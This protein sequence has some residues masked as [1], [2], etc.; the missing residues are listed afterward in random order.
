MIP[1]SFLLCSL[2]YLFIYWVVVV[3]TVFC[4]TS[5]VFIYLLFYFL[6]LSFDIE[7][8]VYRYLTCYWNAKRNVRHYLFDP[9]ILFVANKKNFSVLLD[10]LHVHRHINSLMFS[11]ISKY[12]APK[13]VITCRER[14]D[15]YGH[16]PQ[17][18]IFHTKSKGTTWNY[19]SRY[20][21]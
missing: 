16:G 6:F 8:L 20:N 10:S 12:V 14:K 17:L 1:A 11:S 3:Y 21:F 18:C 19:F 13:N 9:T 15:M 5:T 7:S 4:V 2:I